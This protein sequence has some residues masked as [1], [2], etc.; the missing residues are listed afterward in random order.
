MSPILNVYLI[1]HLKLSS[2][3][4]LLRRKVLVIMN[5]R[6]GGLDDSAL[7]AVSGRSAGKRLFPSG[8]L[9][10][11]VT[12]ITTLPG[13]RRGHCISSQSGLGVDSR[14]WHM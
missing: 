8:G 11:D 2:K 12:G 6:I 5:G 4:I 14:D 3:M 13:G 10:G 1:L 7:A 9:V